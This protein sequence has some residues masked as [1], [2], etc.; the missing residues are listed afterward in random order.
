MTTQPSCFGKHWDPNHVEC[1]GGLDPVYRNPRDDSHRRDRCSW[2]EAC[3][4][5]TMNSSAPVPAPQLPI[6]AHSLV[7]QSMDA[8]KPPQIPPYSPPRPPVYPSPL[9]QQPAP[10]QVHQPYYQQPPPQPQPQQYQY[11]QQHGMLPPNIAQFGPQ[12]V[13]TPYQM[14]GSQMPQYLTIPEPVRDDV[15]WIARLGHEI[16]RSVFKSFGHS[17]AA[18]FDSNPLRR[19][20]K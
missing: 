8:P 6:P 19:H 10:P 2:F 3:H 15:S 17:L 13:F 4:Q 20:N 12:Y 16:L 1:K 18:F 11:P 9:P 7:R 14:P 5:R